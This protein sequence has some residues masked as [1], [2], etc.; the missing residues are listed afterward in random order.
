M[1]CN[2]SSILA[3]PEGFEPPTHGFEVRHSIQLSYGR[4]S[5]KTIAAVRQWSFQSMG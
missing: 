2:P 4:V 3:R 1:T 5:N